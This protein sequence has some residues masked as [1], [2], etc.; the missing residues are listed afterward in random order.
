MELPRLNEQQFRKL[1]D[2]FNHSIA[3]VRRKDGAVADYQMMLLS[4]L[5]RAYRALDDEVEVIE[6][7]RIAE[8]KLSDR[9]NQCVR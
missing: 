1:I 4:K 2:D 5:E 9:R 8:L 7:F 3:N 6:Q